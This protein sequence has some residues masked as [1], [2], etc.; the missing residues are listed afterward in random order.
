MVTVLYRRSSKAA[1]VAIVLLESAATVLRR[2]VVDLPLSSFSSQ[3][4]FERFAGR[5]RLDTIGLGCGFRS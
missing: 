3:V 5:L 1:V 4:S 2:V